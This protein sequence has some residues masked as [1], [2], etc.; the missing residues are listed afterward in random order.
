MRDDLGVDVALPNPP[1]DQLRVL[2]A[3][4]H[5]QDGVHVVVL[6]VVSQWPIPTRCC[7]WYILPSVL[8]AGAITSSAFWNSFTFA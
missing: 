3:Q 6:R 1:R 8:I 4:V 2:R 5:D 7:V